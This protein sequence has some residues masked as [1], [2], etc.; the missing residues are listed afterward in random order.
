[1]NIPDTSMPRIVVVGGGFAG[2]AF[3]KNIPHDKFQIVLIDKHNYHT[4]QPL[5]YQVA[6]AGLE[7]D[8]IAYPLR[9]IFQKI[10]N[11][12]FRMTNVLEISPEK[13]C[14][15]TTIGELEYDHLVLAT[16]T[17]TNFFGNESIEQK[18]MGMK[19]IPEALDI[20]S[21]ILQN[22]EA[23]LLT[24]DLKERESLMNVVIVG[25][26]P[27]GVELAG[28]IAELKRH[29]LP[30]DYPDLD[31]RRMSIHLVEGT[32]R[33]L[34][35][36]SP[37]AGAKAKQYLEKLEVNV[38]LNTMVGDYDGKTITTS[39]KPMLTQTLIWAAG[40]QCK[41]INGIAPEQLVR[42]NRIKVNHFN[43]VE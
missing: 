41:P 5:L 31:F 37:E 22:F 14:I 38:W 34:P 19:F 2:L 35:P 43:Q 4:F 27:T 16:G 11:F 39:G 8:S 32:D 17:V 29:V 3:C 36:F 20:R 30:T 24:D 18:A 25:G 42:G 7:P 1:M 12:F 26:G 40:V 28:A 13:G 9:K 6:T 10:P 23:A 15:R 33:I 21:L